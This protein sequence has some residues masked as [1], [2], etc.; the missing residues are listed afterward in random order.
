MTKSGG[1]KGR[2]KKTIDPSPAASDESEELELDDVDEADAI[3]PAIRK[4]VSTKS[5]AAGRKS[6]T[7]VNYTEEDDEMEDA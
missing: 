6:R 3:K 7:S 2:P 4:T 5:M 1:K